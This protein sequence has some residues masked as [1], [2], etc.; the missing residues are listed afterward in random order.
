M[1]KVF[2]C[3]DD[4]HIRIHYQDTGSILNYDDVNKIE[5][6]YKAKYGSELVGE[7][8]GN[9]H[10]DFSMASANSETYAIENL[11]LG[12]KTY[13]DISEPTD[14]DGK[15]INSEHIRM[16]GI[17]TPCI[18][19]HAEQHN[20]TAL[21]VCTKLHNNKTIKFGITNDNTNLVCRNNKDYTISNVSDFTRKCQYIRYESDTFLINQT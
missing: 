20:I 17:P 11:F 3:A 9:F 19:Y 7:E 16:K 5:N 18:K 14:K 12:R 21:D 15:T 4:C 6:R 13:I 8:L 10:I 1:N 2:S